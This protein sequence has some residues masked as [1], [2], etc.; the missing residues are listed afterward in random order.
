MCMLLHLL[1]APEGDPISTASRS[2][3][4][5]CPSV[6]P[7]T[8]DWLLHLTVHV[9]FF[10]LRAAS[11]VKETFVRAGSLTLGDQATPEGAA[12]AALGPSGPA[13]KQGIPR[14]GSALPPD[15]TPPTQEPLQVGVWKE[16]GIRCSGA[17]LSPPP[18]LGSSYNSGFSRFGYFFCFCF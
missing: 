8:A 6:T 17:L 18:R 7:E 14:L 15:P 2:A 16:G 5:S 11:P 12:S 3:L 1:G 13:C 10:L 4:L 9:W